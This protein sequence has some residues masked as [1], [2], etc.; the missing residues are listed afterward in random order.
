L[1]SLP[2]PPADFAKRSLPTTTIGPTTYFRC[3]ERVYGPVRFSADPK[4]RCTVE[5]GLTCYLSNAFPCAYIEAVPLLRH[6]RFPKFG[7][8]DGWLAGHAVAE[9][10]LTG[11][12]RVVDLTSAGL[13]RLG[14]DN[15]FSTCP[16]DEARRWAQVI[17]DHPDRVDGI[18][19]RSRL[20][21]E[22][23]NLAL[24]D[25]AEAALEVGK[26]HAVDGSPALWLQTLRRYDHVIIPDDRAGRNDD[27]SA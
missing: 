10:Q 3:F 14:I 5:G 20:D 4:H 21:P 15:N 17:F 16:H 7:P 13:A 11:A 24:F 22:F 23:C 19:F 8:T 1:P 25:R 2:S 27:E 26:V 9:I 12:L 6:P 18:L